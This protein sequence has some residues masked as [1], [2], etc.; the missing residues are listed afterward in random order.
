VT[1]MV[2]NVI[3][4]YGTITISEEVIAACVREAV[5]HTDGV[6]DFF[7]G[8]PDTLSQNIL[9]KELKFRGIKISEEEEGIVVDVQVVVQY[10][11][12]IPEIAWNLQKNIKTELEEM[13][14]AVVKAV[15][16]GVQ[17]VSV[18]KEGERAHG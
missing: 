16:I 7:G 3:D 8:L 10:G 14:D 2:N 4:G 12:K 6:C 13:T 15:N 17:S 11:V 1:G 9:R 18:P 5:F